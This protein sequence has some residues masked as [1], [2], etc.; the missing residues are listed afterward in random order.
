MA[1]Q[2]PAVQNKGMLVVAVVLGVVAVIVYNV[3][4]AAVRQQSIGALVKVLQFDRDMKRGEKIDLTKDVSMKEI[5]NALSA[6][7][8]DVAVADNFEQLKTMTQD[9]ILNRDVRKGN[10][11]STSMVLTNEREDPASKVHNPGNVC[12]AVP[13]RMD[14]SRLLRP[15]ARVNLTAMIPVSG[16][17]VIAERII[18][19]VYVLGVGSEIETDSAA[20]GSASD[21]GLMSYR[22]I[23][24][25]VSPQ[26]SLDLEQVLYYIGGGVN[27]ELIPPGAPPRNDRTAG[28]VKPGLKERLEGT[29]ATPP[30]GGGGG[31]PPSGGGSGPL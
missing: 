23:T 9:G 25:E 17:K 26:A 10:F 28:I 7:L 29:G 20:P 27:V 16:G 21:Q 24:I 6:G 12:R 5:S 1:E 3:Q 13:V 11:F 31:A 14:L 4:V 19:D 8:G 18:E 2:T 22:K 30:K 15:G